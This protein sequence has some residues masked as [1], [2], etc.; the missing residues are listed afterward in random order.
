LVYDE[1]VGPGFLKGYV[2]RFA[3]KSHDHRG[4]PE[5]RL[6]SLPPPSKVKPSHNWLIDWIL[7]VL[8]SRLL[9]QNP[10]RVTTL[11]HQEDWAKFSGA[12]SLFSLC[13]CPRA[14]SRTPLLNDVARAG[15]ICNQDPFPQEDI[16]WGTLRINFAGLLLFL[17]FDAR[18][19]S[20]FPWLR[21]GRNFTSC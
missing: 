7:V 10:G 3:Q 4:T 12:V 9:V 21:F 16:V 11:V 17:F 6:C 20:L 1:T 2:R 15:V 19:Y 18:P 8:R 14:Q 5:V 13:F